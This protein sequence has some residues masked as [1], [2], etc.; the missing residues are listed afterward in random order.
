MSAVSSPDRP[1]GRFVRMV[2]NLGII[3]GAPRLLRTTSAGHAR[4]HNTV[5]ALAPS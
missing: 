2:Y 3:A 5:E 1:D 4:L